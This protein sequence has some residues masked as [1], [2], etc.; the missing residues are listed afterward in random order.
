M[1]ADS[2]ATVDFVAGTASLSESG[3]SALPLTVTADGVDTLTVTVT[4]RDTYG[5]PVGGQAVIL[6]ASGGGNV[7]EDPAGPTNADGIAV[8]YI[9]STTAESKTIGFE[10]GG[11]PADSTVDVEFVAGSFSLSESGIAANPLTVTADGVD[12][13]DITVTVRDANGNPVSGSTV[14]LEVSGSDNDITQ[15]A[16]LTGSDGIATGT[17][18]STVAEDKTVSFRV[19]TNLADSTTAVQF[20]AGPVN[21]I[22]STI[23]GNRDTVFANGGD[24]LTVTVTA[25]D[26]YGNPVSGRDVILEINPFRPQNSITQPGLTGSDGIAVGYVFSTFAEEKIVRALIDG[27]YV[28]EQDTVLF[29]PDEADLAQSEVVGNKN[30]ITADGVDELAVTVTVRDQLGNPVE[31]ATVV[32]EATGGAEGNPRSD[33]W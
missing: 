26:V 1:L 27:V 24:T 13:T 25:L 21:L 28:T 2:T 15:P 30:E 31:G 22:E 8:G 10:I 11:T 5:N 6:T 20:V 14:T 4:I 32:V 17:V 16:G 12:E 18:T 23:A 19:D 9:F 7:I 29:I 33:K 3:L